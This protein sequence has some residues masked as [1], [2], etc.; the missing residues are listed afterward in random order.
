RGGSPVEGAPPTRAL[1]YW[2]LPPVVSPRTLPNLSE[3]VRGDTRATLIFK[4]LNSEVELLEHARSFAPQFGEARR[5]PLYETLEPIAREIDQLKALYLAAVDEIRELVELDR[6]E[7]LVETYADLDARAELLRRRGQWLSA[8]IQELYFSMYLRQHELALEILPT[9]QG[10]RPEE[11]ER[12]R[13]LTESGL[14]FE[15][16]IAEK[17]RRREEAALAAYRLTIEIQGLE[18]ERDRELYR[19]KQNEIRTRIESLSGDP[20]SSYIVDILRE[21]LARIDT[22]LGSLDLR[23]AYQSA[24]REEVDAILQGNVAG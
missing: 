4:R 5:L 3:L 16:S 8:R 13:V 12:Y 10:A 7:F 22:L 14:R 15:V 6:E 9:I 18:L 21:D 11:V 19:A 20:S 1:Q 24:L 23:A 2:T 17:E